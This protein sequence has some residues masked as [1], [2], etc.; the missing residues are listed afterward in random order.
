[1]SAITVTVGADELT[2]QHGTS[3]DFRRIYSN[4]SGTPIVECN[5]IA[6]GNGVLMWSC[7]RWWNEGA[8][9]I[10]VQSAHECVVD[11]E[12]NAK[13]PNWDQVFCRRYEYPRQ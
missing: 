5:D 1:M 4:D 13:L 9:M 12:F 7:V 11:R 8:K 2:I 10:E 6:F 3:R